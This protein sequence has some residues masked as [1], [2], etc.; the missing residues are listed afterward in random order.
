MSEVYVS[1]AVEGVEV[2]S[3][4]EH[5]VIE[6]ND[7]K[8]DIATMTFGD[9]HLILS[10]VFHEGLAVEIGLG[11]SDGH[12]LIFRGIITSIRAYFPARGQA[13]V[14]VQA[15][16]N[17][18]LLS[19]EPK[20]YR[21]SNTTVSQIVGEVA[22]NYGLVPGTITPTSDSALD[23]TRPRQQ[24]EETDLA[25]LYRLARDYD[26]K[27][28]LEHGDVPPDK[29]SFVSTGSLIEAEP[30][31]EVLSFNQ[32]LVEFYATFDAF[33][34][35]AEE[36]LVTTDPASGDK[37]EIVE[38]LVSAS[39]LT[40]VPDP[41]RIAQ[42][43]DSAA[44]ITSLV[45]KSM[46]KRAALRDF[47]RKSARVAGA[48]ARPTSD[49]SQAYGDRSRRLGQSGRGRARG[50]IW[51]RPRSRVSIVGHGG[52]W[53]GAW[54]LAQVRHELDMRRRSYLSAFVCTR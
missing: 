23:E 17:L 20:T 44:F 45:A 3:L 2:T 53:S 25:F 12:A 40:W 15:M 47:W 24:V 21:W 39:E 49:Q 48:P 11:Y 1:I 52:R 29:L 13:H 46:A 50:S 38:D 36:Q 16:D 30:I 35:A 27:L 5:L 7:V 18:I 32:N 6:E 34:T 28:Y 4:L 31:A 51:L 9:S 42:M 8:A 43:G 33:A 19:L 26:C 54:Y 37:V 41:D 10:D 22:Q 14:E